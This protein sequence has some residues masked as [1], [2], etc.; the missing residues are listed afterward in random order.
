M[1]ANFAISPISIFAPPAIIIQ[2]LILTN[3]ASAWVTP[4][5]HT[6]MLLF[7]QLRPCPIVTSIGGGNC[8]CSI[9]LH[10][11]LRCH[12]PAWSVLIWVL[13]FALIDVTWRVTVCPVH[14]LSVPHFY[15]L[16]IVFFCPHHLPR[17]LPAGK[18]GWR[19]FTRWFGYTPRPWTGNLWLFLNNNNNVIRL[20]LCIP[21]NVS[22][23]RRREERVCR[24]RWQGHMP[25]FVWAD[26]A[27]IEK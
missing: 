2:V 3:S 19:S 1:E 8:S 4:Q 22:K 13:L 17:L 26:Q 6:N 10:G 20:L 15:F 12:L 9:K 11:L 24:G 25:T 16:I 27:V 7:V 18:V 5:R 21:P 14:C 23:H